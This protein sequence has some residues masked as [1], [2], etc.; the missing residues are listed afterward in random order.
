MNQWQVAPKTKR[1]LQRFE[2]CCGH[3]LC[4]TR[5]SKTPRDEDGTR[6]MHQKQNRK[7]TDLK[8]STGSILDINVV[9]FGKHESIF[10][11]TH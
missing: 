1:W 6:R 2:T 10:K 8:A 9:K 7:T 11:L 4:L 3:N 5:A